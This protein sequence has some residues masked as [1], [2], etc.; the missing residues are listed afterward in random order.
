MASHLFASRTLNYHNN[1]PG[2]NVSTDL[3]MLIFI[4]SQKKTTEK[5]RNDFTSRLVD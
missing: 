3:V 2:T 5:P 4:A 1:G